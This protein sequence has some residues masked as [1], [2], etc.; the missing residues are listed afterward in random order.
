MSRTRAIEPLRHAAGSRDVR[1]VPGA[2]QELPKPLRDSLEPLLGHSF[3]NVRI[4]ADSPAAERARSLGARAYAVGSEIHF[5]AGEFAP[6]TSSGRALLAHE[7]AH[8]VQQQDAQGGP[9]VSRS[10]NEAAEAEAK[11][12]GRVVAAGR[13]F[14]PLMRTAETIAMQELETPVVQAPPTRTEAEP[15]PV[16]TEAASERADAERAAAEERTAAEETFRTEQLG[17]ARDRVDAASH[18]IAKQFA[19]M[20]TKPEDQ[21]APYRAKITAVERQLVQALKASLPVLEQRVADL[22]TR[23]SRGEDVKA[24]LAATKKELDDNKADLDRLAGAF[25]PEKGEA[26]E[27]VYDTKLSGAKCMVRA[28]E[29]L[30]ALLSPGKS[31]EIQKDV[32]TKA[33]ETMKR[34]RVNI[35]HFITVMDTVNAAKL[36]GPKQRARWS[37]S[38][39]KWT[40][41]LES[42]IRPKIHSSAPAFYF[43]G[44]ALA[45]AYHSVIVG[46]STWGDAP[47]TLWCD[48]SGCVEVTG[49]LDDFARGQA[50]GYEIGYSDWD[51]YVWQIVPP[52]EASLLAQEEAK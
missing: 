42:L 36:A 45:E 8:V 40:P 51:T 24:E 27:K 11:Y 47:K 15:Q 13:R 23:A 52:A 37:K 29:G 12:A 14:Q 41:T 16:S 22:R 2:G 34:R 39:R 10:V 48:Q 4:H 5:G 30:G 25:T 49:K 46:V 18:S 26:F 9:E 17:F 21:R 7:L 3:A 19:E 31:A 35:D 50:E 6:Q 38:G 44:L 33:E 20:K 43:F 32:E 28:Y 1:D